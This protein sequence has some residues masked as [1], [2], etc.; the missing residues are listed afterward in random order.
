MMPVWL[1]CNKKNGK[2]PNT[3]HDKETFLSAKSWIFTIAILSLGNRKCK[4]PR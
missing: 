3:L 1:N 2:K 4:Y